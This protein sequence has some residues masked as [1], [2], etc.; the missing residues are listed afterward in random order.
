[1]PRTA[2]EPE[3]GIANRLLAAAGRR[4]GARLASEHVDASRLEPR[5]DAARLGMYAIA[6]FV[7]VLTLALAVAG[8]ALVATGVANVN[9]IEII[10]GL[11]LF[12]FAWFMRPQPERVPTE[13]V[14]PRAATP[15]LFGLVDRVAAALEV[16]TIDLLVVDASWN[17]SWRVAGYRR[18]RVLTLG[19]PL[20]HA[21]EAQQ[22]VAL[23]AHELG[24]ARNGDSTRGL[25]VGS[26]INGLAEL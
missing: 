23:I 11:A 9:V 16:R 13:G 22:R 15:T 6:T 26:S 20:F 21:L 24:H 10:V 4:S 25:Y 18:R 7:F 12:G 19:L 8:V 3:E 1:V 5:L 17:A 14:V 2:D